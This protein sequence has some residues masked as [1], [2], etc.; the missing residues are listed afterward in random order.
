MN[1]IGY[2][3]FET[4]CDETLGA[5][6]ATFNF[7]EIP[8]EEYIKRY[9]ND[10]WIIEIS[11]VKYFPYITVSFDFISLSGEKLEAR[12]LNSMLREKNSANVN[13]FDKIAAVIDPTD[14]RD[15]MLYVRDV[16]AKLYYELLVG[17]VTFKDYQEYMQSKSSKLP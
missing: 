6:L 16:L 13:H 1:D 8:G 3:S 2:E 9:K 11:M 12:V 5:F 14:F 4:D 15:Q 17:K 7:F 10:F